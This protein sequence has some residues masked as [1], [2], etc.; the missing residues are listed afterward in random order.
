MAK[1]YTKKPKQLRQPIK[2]ENHPSFSEPIDEEGAGIVAGGAY[3]TYVD[4]EGNTRNEYEL[5]SRYRQIS[6]QPEIEQAIDD[7]VNEAIDVDSNETVKLNLDN[8]KINENVKSLFLDEFDNI[9]NLLNFKHNSYEIFKRWYIDGKLNYHVIIDVEKP[10]EGIKELRYIDP[11]RLKKIKEMEVKKQFNVDMQV[12]ANEYY[13][14]LDNSTTSGLNNNLIQTNFA[15]SNQALKISLDN[16]IVV[17]SGILDETN[18]MVL[19]HLSKAIKPL[20]QLRT[21]EDAAVIYR[22][23]RAPE[24]R[25]FYV[26]VGNLP[27]QKAEQY[28]KE[29]MTK[30]KNRL[31]Y[32]SVDGSVVDDRKYMTMLEDFWLA[33]REGAG[34]TE[35]NTLPSGTNLGEM[36]DVEYFQKKL[37]MALNVPV[38]RLN[39]SEVGFNLGR[40]AEISRD[41]IKFT[42]FIGRLRRKFS[43]L[44]MSC[45]EKQLILKNIINQQEWEILKN[46]IIIEYAMDNH[47]EEFKNLDILKEKLNSIETIQPFIGTFYSKLW[48]Q[49]NI[50]KQT[51]EEI[52]QIK[53]ENIQDQET[54]IALQQQFPQLNQNGTINDNNQ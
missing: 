46:D 31:V 23:T 38:S 52:E 30:Y 40:T 5:I 1:T 14:F 32:N 8:L 15:T 28:L 48:V 7:I 9:L 34:N 21:L 35:I 10:N 53:Q 54:Q 43:K 20:N 27:K 18:K 51:D 37:Y 36:T 45:L 16:I 12:V 6:F 33:R 2:K 11:R 29:V 24:R 4:F 25:V 3:G 41:E 42:K 50:L 47:F 22:L 19:S 39:P 49:K 26:G 44:F 17:T 13:L